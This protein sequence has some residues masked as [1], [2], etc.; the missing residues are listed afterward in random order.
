MVTKI[1]LSK[2]LKLPEFILN[3][4]QIEFA[5]RITLT[6]YLFPMFK[7]YFDFIHM[8]VFLSLCWA[9]L[10]FMNA[11]VYTINSMKAGLQFYHSR[12]VAYILRVGEL[13]DVYRPD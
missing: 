5:H 10:L 13:V 2:N 11:Y 7:Y 8:L 12:Y 4:E 3:E 6:I 1:L 9:S